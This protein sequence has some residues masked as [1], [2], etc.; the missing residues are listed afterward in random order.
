[1]R[2]RALL[3]AI[4]VLALAA[5][6]AAAAHRNAALRAARHAKNGTL[7]MLHKTK[8]G[9]VLATS[10]GMTLYLYTPDGKNRSNCYGSCAALWP[11]LIAKGKPRAGAG[12]RQKLLGVTRRRDG[13][14]QVTYHGHP[15][16]RYSGDSKPGQVKGEGYGGIWYALNAAGNKVEPHTST[17]TTTTSGGYGGGGG[18]YGG[19][20]Y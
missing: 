18:G 10:G 19:G 15:L 13:K 14:R 5:S 11:P 12:V 9:K 6:G 16:Y 8:L 7:V 3:A 1:M 17:G 20:G 4:V 2:R